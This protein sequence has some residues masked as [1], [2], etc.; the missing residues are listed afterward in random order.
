MKK[1]LSILL[2]FSLLM[3][4]SLFSCENK[5]DNKKDD[6]DE[7]E[8]T[9]E[10]T[11][12]EKAVLDRILENM[13]ESD[14]SFSYEDFV[15]DFF[16]DFYIKRFDSSTG[17][18]DMFKKNGYVVTNKTNNESLYQ[19]LQNGKLCTVNRYNGGQSQ[20]LNPKEDW[21]YAYPLSIFTAFGVDM[22]G[23][24]STETSDV[25]EP[26]LTLEDLSFSKDK[27]TVK[28]SDRYIKE[29]ATALTASFEFTNSELEEFLSSMDASGEYTL[30][31]EK[32]S[33]NICGEIESQGKITINAS[34]TYKNCVPH[35]SEVEISLEKDDILTSMKMGQRDMKFENGKLVDITLESTQN[36]VQT[37]VSQGVSMKTTTVKKSTYG[38]E[39]EGGVPS[40]IMINVNAD[41]TAEYAGQKQTSN[42]TLIFWVVD[43]NL[44]YDV[45]SDGLQ[46]SHIAAEGV[47]F[48]TPANKTIDSDVI[49]LINGN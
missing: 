4:M 44:T 46:Q 40:N 5:S 3:S 13:S 36:I 47:V 15:D 21:P 45:S 2:I 49:N 16:G 41:V 48:E 18:V 33:F 17:I 12:E 34:Y 8:P 24:Y 11:A 7:K 43:G 22:S 25:Q 27:K 39:T 20:R 31:E 14:S 42:S 9:E 35:S 28:F 19:T 30:S 37:I 10:L 6:D 26:T 32:Y 23:V 29:L 38:F 1:F